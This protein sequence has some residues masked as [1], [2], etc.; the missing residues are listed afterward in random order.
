M[1]LLL[2]VS[3]EASPSSLPKVYAYNIWWHEY[4]PSLFA[5]L[6]QKHILLSHGINKENLSNNQEPLKLVFISLFK[7][8]YVWFR[9]E[10]IKAKF[11]CLSH[12]VVTCDVDC[13]VSTAHC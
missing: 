11:F 13:D 12:Y 9:G 1:D 8:L 7:A 3:T 4:L 5:S 2:K 10:T 6:Y